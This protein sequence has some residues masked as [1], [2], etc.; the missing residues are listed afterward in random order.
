MAVAV[1]FP[2]INHP[3][4]AAMQ[5]TSI[6][7]FGPM[8]RERLIVETELMHQKIDP[9]LPFNPF[10]APVEKGLMLYLALSSPRGD[11]EL[12]GKTLSLYSFP[13]EGARHVV[14]S[15][16]LSSNVSGMPSW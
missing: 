8:P 11:S 9:A 5:V 16:D 14:R 2:P 3:T 7:A 15:D 10:P 6:Q 13:Y 4:I 1:S 12:N